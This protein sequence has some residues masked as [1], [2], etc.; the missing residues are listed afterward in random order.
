MESQEQLKAEV[1]DLLN[2]ILLKLSSIG[3][4]PTVDDVYGSYSEK[5]QIGKTPPPILNEDGEIDE[6][7]TSYQ[8][9]IIDTEV[10]LA[11][12]KAAI[13]TLLET[14]SYNNGI[15]MMEKFYTSTCY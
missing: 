9:P 1:T 3:Q 5:T 11:V 15:R 14:K 4:V 6:D 7:E 2:Q 12:I 13:T 10:E 8:D